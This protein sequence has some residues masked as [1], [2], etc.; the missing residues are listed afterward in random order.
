L[1]TAGTVENRELLLTRRADLAILQNGAVPMSGTCA[2]APLYQD[3]VHVVVRSDRNLD[4]IP[5]LAGRNVSL[6]LVGSGMRRTGQTILA[7]YQI[8]EASL[9]GTDTYFGALA[10]DDK[11]D[12][13]IVTTGLLN[14]ELRQ[15][16]VGRKFNLLP[17]ES[18]RALATVDPSMEPAMIPRGM[19]AEG[20]PLPPLDVPSVA[21]TAFLASRDDASAELVV[22]ALE[23]LYDDDLRSSI[24]TLIPPTA[25]ASWHAVPVHPSARS[26]F[27]PYGGIGLVSNLVQT[28]DGAKELL[29]ALCAGLFLIWR[30]IRVVRG[31]KEQQHVAMLKERLDAFIQQLLR[32]ERSQ[33]ET[34][35]PTTLRRLLRDA[36]DV[37]LRALEELT[38][39]TLRGDRNFS[40]FLTEASHLL[41]IIQAKL[42]L[43]VLHGQRMPMEDAV[44]HEGD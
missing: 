19:Y 16:L 33:V 24:P 38:N 43:H 42:M 9:G 17:I 28:L 10:S 3:V 39:E 8:A 4:A 32:I 35:D 11:L 34:D 27:D 23:V 15:L 2:L 20:P 6:G 1:V 40:I 7:H 22:R 37:K 31:R 41:R 13:A 21:V 25:A 18:A 44:G 36:T 5:N 12:A 29:V 30:Q 14:P 26:Y